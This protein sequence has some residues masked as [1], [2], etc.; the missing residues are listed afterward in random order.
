MAGPAPSFS[1]K[2]PAR[3]DS[4]TTLS[5]TLY[6]LKKEGYT[7]DFNLKLNYLEGRRYAI[8]VFAADF[9]VD[10]YFR[11]EGDSDPDDEAVV[12]AISSARLQVKGTLVNAY[13]LYSDNVVGELIKALRNKSSPVL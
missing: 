3:M 7:Q 12:Y 6:T 11:F 8:Q 5:Q 9:V 10:K 1:F 4:M 2:T 13:G